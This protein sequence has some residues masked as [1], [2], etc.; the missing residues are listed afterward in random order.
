MRYPMTA[1][2]ALRSLLTVG[3]AAV[4]AVCGLSGVASAASVETDRP[5]YLDGPVNITASGLAPNDTTNYDVW[6]DG[7]YYGTLGT[8]AAGTGRYV[9]TL[10]RR[11]DPPIG[12]ERV[13]IR[14]RTS[15]LASISY[16]RTPLAVLPEIVGYTNTAGRIH[17]RAYGFVGART[18]YA[19]YARNGR[20]Y[21]TVAIGALSAPCGTL[22]KTVAKFPFR[23]IRAGSWRIQFDG[24]RRYT[25]ADAID[26]R[27]PLVA[28]DTSVTAT[29]GKRHPCKRHGRH[30]RC[31]GR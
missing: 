27:F 24:H 19:H 9:H 21:R 1:R 26:A 17:L 25:K 14:Q 15:V 7:S 12:A 29:I 13:E 18:L 2:P 30:R 8:N 5:C 4:I 28:H 22:S 10:D 23:P 3:A 31:R 6:I 20:L 16:L 11:T